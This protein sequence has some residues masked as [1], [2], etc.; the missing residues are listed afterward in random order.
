MN[1]IILYNLNKI[2]T[3]NDKNSINLLINLLENKKINIEN[4]I[5]NYI[6]SKNIFDFYPDIIINK[7]EYNLNYLK[8]FIINYYFTILYKKFN[9]D[10]IYNIINFII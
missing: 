2:I 10:I 3:K 5:D 9:D 6:L 7:E 4:I 8:S 1:D